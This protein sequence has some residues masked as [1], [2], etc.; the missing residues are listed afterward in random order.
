M[1]E[2]RS[3]LQ[4]YAM[5]F[6]TDMGVYWILKFTLFPLGFHIPFLSLLFIVLTLAVPFIG[7]HYAKTYRDKICG[8]VITFT[9]ALLF[10]LF[11]YMFASLL[12]AVAH[13]VYLQFIDHGFII[14]S[15]AQLWE[16]LVIKTPALAEH[17]EIVEET[18]NTVSLL[19]PINITMQLLS[20]N[21]FWGSI[22]AI[23]TGLMVMKKKQPGNSKLPH[24]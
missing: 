9:H 3:H 18:I 21:L 12:V 17:K 5:H 24:N 13:Y 15:Y 2:N 8:G 11:M 20:G 6:G 19:T 1:T 23:P 4:K 22:L 7:Y 10:S 16:E 14:N